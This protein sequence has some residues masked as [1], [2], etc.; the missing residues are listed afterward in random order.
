VRAVAAVAL[1]A[2]LAAGCSTDDDPKADPQHEP[3]QAASAADVGWSPCDGVSAAVVGRFA[4]Q[5]MAEQT[6]TAD[7][8]R[9]AFT[10]VAEG[11]PAFD[12]NYLW[13]D[14]GLD[15]AWASMGK[16]AGTVTDVTLPGADAARL[17]VQA[18]K[19]GVLATGFVQTD[20]LV[21]S[22]NAVQVRPYDERT[23]VRATTR[24]LA[25]LAR[26]APDPASDPAS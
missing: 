8:P 16:V 11:G 2:A 14:G 6:G 5:K 13:F 26:N 17:V 19:S 18:G 9:C 22:V 4:G 24:L 20:G 12:L 25:E 15:E 10:P 3:E 23:V 1:V 7:Q 21:Q